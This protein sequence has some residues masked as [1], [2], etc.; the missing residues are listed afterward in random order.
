MLTTQN[1]KLNDNIPSR[2]TMPNTEILQGQECCLGK[3]GLNV[4]ELI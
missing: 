2:L 1:V 3:M 4:K